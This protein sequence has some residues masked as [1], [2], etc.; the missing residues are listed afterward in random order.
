M[1]TYWAVAAA[2][3]TA[4]AAGAIAH[5]GHRNRNSRRVLDRLFPEHPHDG[6][7][8]QD[9]IDR[10]WSAIHDETPQPPH[11]PHGRHERP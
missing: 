1:V 3:A 4:F 7:P 5:H 11:S 6:G 10:I 9:T 2:F 8:D